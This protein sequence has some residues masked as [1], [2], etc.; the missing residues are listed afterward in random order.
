M[1]TREGG[2]EVLTSELKFLST[3]GGWVVDGGCGRL[4]LPAVELVAGRADAGDGLV[5]AAAAG[6]GAVVG[7]GAGAAAVVAEAAPTLGF[8]W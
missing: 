7:V 4:A 3:P 5:L 8:L 1:G 2:A 6:G